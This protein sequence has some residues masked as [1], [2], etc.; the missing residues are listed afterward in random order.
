[1]RNYGNVRWLQ[2]LVGQN[3][4]LTVRKDFGHQTSDMG[5]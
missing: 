2:S 5:T 1:M 4:S 3:A